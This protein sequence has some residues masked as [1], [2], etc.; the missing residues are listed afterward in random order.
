ML[1]DP[2][3]LN[4]RSIFYTAQS[5]RDSKNFEE[6]AKWYKLYTLYKDTWNEELYYSYLQLGIIYTVLKFDFEKI[7]K[8]YKSAINV[9]NDRAEAYLQLGMFYN[10]N[11]KY[12][13]SYD[14]LK[15]GKGIRFEDVQKRYILFLNKC[16]YGKYINDELSVACYWLGKYEE[17][18]TL[19]NEILDDPDF[20]HCKPRLLD[21]NNHFKRKLN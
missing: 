8:C 20:E 18:V 5:Y 14:L 6:A 7:E 3:G 17:G 4:T 16:S 13:L 21:N 15:V 9:I 19:L 10:Q 2:D 1:S 11:Q 12:N